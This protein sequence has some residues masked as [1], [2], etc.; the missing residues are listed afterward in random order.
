MKYLRIMLLAVIM[1]FTFAGAKAQVVVQARVGHGRYWHHH[2]WYH[3]R[4]WRHHHWYY[5]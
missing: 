1:A 5:Y 3:H 2:R 4:H